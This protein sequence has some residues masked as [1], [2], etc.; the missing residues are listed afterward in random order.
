MRILF[1]SLTIMVCSWAQSVDKNVIINS[2]NYYFGTGSS[3]NADE[4][5]KLALDALAQQIAVKISS[6]FERKV[7]QNGE[8]YQER[9]Q[10]VIKSQALA[11][12]EEVQ[13]IQRP[14]SN[15]RIEVFCYVTRERVQQMF[16]ERRRL[17]SDIAA[18]AAQFAQNLNLAQALKYYYF[19]AVLINS[20]PDQSVM[21]NGVNYSTEIP[22][23]IN[24]ILDNIKFRFLYDRRL[25]DKEREITLEIA[26]QNKPEATLDFTFWNGTTQQTVCGRD[27]RATFLL[28]GG[29]TAFEQIKDVQPKYCYYDARREFKLL[30]ALWEL[31]ERPEFNRS[32]NVRLGSSAGQDP[33]LRRVTIRDDA[34]NPGTAVKTFIKTAPSGD[35][36]IK[37][38]FD[39]DIPCAKAILSEVRVFLNTMATG[40]AAAVQQH[41]RQDAFLS[42]KIQNYLR[43]N[44]PQPV[45]QNVSAAL[46]KT[47][48]GWELRSLQVLHW[49]PSLQKHANEYLVLD[50]DAQGKL[51][52]FNLCIQENLYKRFVQLNFT[53]AKWEN[54]HEIIKF[55]EKY[56]TAYMTRDLK[57]VDLMF[58]EDAIIIVGRV[59]K[60]RKLPQGVI[61]YE[62]MGPTPEFKQIRLDK[63]EYL[64]RL[65]ATF[66]D[67]EDIAVEF[68]TFDI[69][70]KNDSANV[71]GVQ[72][73]QNYSS[74]NYGDEGYLYL[75]I[76]FRETDPVIYVRAWQPN[77]WNPDELI[78]NGN[79]KI[80]TK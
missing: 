39:D 53:G 76:D 5:G 9:I 57:T 32:Q 51:Y 55:I 17:V 72:M 28:L 10:S 70:Q 59:L 69:F 21:Y 13:Q 56:R 49:Y 38:D 63:T 41:Y 42:N 71:Y 29:S 74:S 26:Y 37:L 24:S 14:M 73:R 12:L 44:H 4:A 7:E 50:F 80:Y 3:A 8:H 45:E 60:Q 46:N 65:N 52:D 58:A 43:Y 35:Y 61:Q 16:A 23:R 78:K 36:N 77:V 64:Q 20:L 22:H 30:A 1:I 48:R 31:V 6:T 19:A 62:R 66:A 34:G 47:A 15:G 54:R 11:T 2:G 25:S 40:S 18:Q 68:S 79:F 75:L 67:N 27:G 33:P